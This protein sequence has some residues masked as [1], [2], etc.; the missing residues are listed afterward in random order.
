[1]QA[2]I[3]LSLCYVGI[4]ATI[5]AVYFS[6]KVFEETL[7][8]EMHSALRQDSHLIEA[9]YDQNSEIQ[10][11]QFASDSLRITL[12][13][14]EGDVLFESDGQAE[15]MGNHMSRPEVIAAFKEGSGEGVRH[16]TTLD[17]S[18]YYY[19]VKLT[20]GNILRLGMKQAN[21]QQVVSR[22]TPYLLGLIA[23]IIAVSILIAIGL[24]K[25]FVRPIKK[26][27]EK[28]D[29]AEILE[30]ESLY[31]EIAPFIKTIRN[32]NRELAITIEKLH[33]EEQKTTRLKDEFTANAAHELKTPL[34]TISGY[35][36]M[37]EA[38]I[39]KPED[40]ARFAGKIH[41]EAQRMLNITN[42]ILTLS[43]LDKPS[44]QTVNLD[45]DVDLWSTATDCVGLLTINA[46][47]KN[48]QLSLQ[49]EVGT[50]DRSSNH[51]IKGNEKLIFEM[52]YNLVDNAIR[53]TNENG[54]VDVIV[55]G[56]SISV[57]DNGI[58]I[59]EE[60]KDRVFERFF[61]VDKSHSRE[62]GGTGLGLA[63]VKHVAEVHNATID[64][65]SIV[66]VGTQIRVSF[67]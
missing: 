15:N 12:I 60:Y 11:K 3:S 66:G 43:K 40:T 46:N 21:I 61:R 8:S 65:K 32:K 24:G 53:Y 13:S 42:D 59:P 49:G 51:T 17:A 4:L 35:A 9:A 58:G 55:V 31:K 38:G 2:R 50:V 5:F 67:P 52:I 16:S 39:A 22:T 10:L 41:K 23:V 18:V 34:T 57:I 37:L 44:K 30:D 26:L 48:I 33:D 29:D 19:A 27:S 64:F 25:I 28:L 7:V 45:E 6:T 36:E 54:K 14:K 47:K 20:D 62:T 63:I 56:N 1:M